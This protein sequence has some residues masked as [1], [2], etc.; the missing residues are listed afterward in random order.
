VEP[1][2]ASPRRPRGAVPHGVEHAIAFLPPYESGSPPA[3]RT[4]VFFSCFRFQARPL[5]PGFFGAP[6]LRLSDLF[7]NS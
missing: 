4:A 7:L 1:R 2:P 3:G 6:E 5:R